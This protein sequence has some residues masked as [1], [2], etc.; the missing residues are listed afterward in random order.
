MTFPWFSRPKRHQ[1]RQIISFPLMVRQITVG[2]LES[3][4]H[5]HGFLDPSAIDFTNYILPLNGPSISSI[6][7]GSSHPC[8]Y[9]S[10]L[11]RGVA[12]ID[13]FCDSEPRPVESSRL[14]R[15]VSRDTVFEDDTILRADFR[16]RAWKHTN[17]GK[18]K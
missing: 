6:F 18:N 7:T 17:R 13:H 16:Y 2:D 1:L 8:L 5:S 11:S 12:L 14:S 9:A 10:N 15:H 4:R 3:Q